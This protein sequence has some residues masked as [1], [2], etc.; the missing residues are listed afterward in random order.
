[1]GKVRCLIEGCVGRAMGRGLCS[2]HYHRLQRY[3]DPLGRP[4]EGKTPLSVLADVIG[5]ELAREVVALREGRDRSKPF[6]TYRAGLTLEMFQRASDPRLS[7]WEYVNRA[8]NR[9][10][11][12]QEYLKACVHYDVETGV[13]V[14]RLPMGK[15][16]EGDVLG[17]IGNHGYLTVTV[18]GKAYLAHRLAW[19]HEHGQWPFL[20]D[21]IDRDRHNN[22]IGNLREC[23][24]EENA[25]NV[26]PMKGTASGVEG[27]NWSAR[28]KK[29]VAKISG[30]GIHRTL[31]HFDA[32]EEAASVRA[33]AV[34]EQRGHFLHSG[35][36]AA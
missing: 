13:F 15:R 28:R 8:A 31:G 35:S 17:S 18:G 20:I 7:A 23:T 33:K 24:Y 10:N 16:N 32:I 12:T 9:M 27:V 25:W 11:L 21:H 26:T 3:G 14:A 34:E 36:E 2:A 5:D 30:G 1:M 29:W 22:R 6:D 19:F 4:E